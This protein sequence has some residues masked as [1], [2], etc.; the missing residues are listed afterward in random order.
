LNNKDLISI[1]IGY[2]IRPI[3]Q[4]RSVI[5]MKI[6][7][8][9]GLRNK[10]E[11]YKLMRGGTL[12]EA[13]RIMY[14]SLISGFLF[15]VLIFLRMVRWNRFALFSQD[16][17]LLLVYC[18]LLFSLLAL[19]FGIFLCIVASVFRILKIRLSIPFQNLLQTI[20][21]TFFLFWFL[22][23]KYAYL[24]MYYHDF[25]A[26]LQN[27]WI[28]ASLWTLRLLLLLIISWV[29]TIALFQFY[30]FFKKIKKSYVLVLSV[31]L[32]SLFLSVYEYYSYKSGA[33]FDPSPFAVTSQKSKV[34]FIG[35]DGAEWKIIDSLIG[36]NLLPSFKHLKEQGSYG[37]LKTIN[38]ESPG[39][40]TSMVTGVTPRNHGIYKHTQFKF[41]GMKDYIQ[42]PY[43]LGINS[44][45]PTI[46][47]YLGLRL[48][49]ITL[50]TSNKREVPALWNIL[51]LKNR[52]NITTG[53]LATHPVEPIHGLIVSPRITDHY[54]KQERN[55]DDIM[56]YLYSAEFFDRPIKFPDKVDSN[57]PISH[58]VYFSDLALD[59]IRNKDTYE[60]FLLYLEKIDQISHLSW[61][62]MEP[63]KF[64]FVDQTELSE[65]RDSIEREYI[66][67]DEFLGKL[68]EVIDEDYS[69]ILC[70]DHGFGP[71]LFEKDH[72]GGHNN[73]PDGVFIGYG[74]IFKKNHYVEN[75]SVYDICPTILHILGFPVAQD[76]P[77]QVIQQAFAS[78]FQSDIRQID[79]YGRRSTEHLEDNEESFKKEIE[80]LKSLGYIN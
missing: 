25:P 56:R 15:G 32:I 63:E 17:F 37:R 10:F 7:N 18:I 16:V 38:Y 33:K 71:A 22:F 44:F 19:V 69:L 43:Y 4:N 67:K 11:D 79:T 41:P 3:N 46:F 23:S 40:W 51:S 53:W 30:F 1:K 78:E 12:K 49:K 48:F 50:I 27:K 26:F 36:K 2:T 64:F 55:A 14:I 39:I 29:L 72:Y 28:M 34:I 24:G 35:I 57:H 21:P 42:A 13:T 20:V 65:H 61:K 73:C 62:Y 59:L 66:E 74:K 60:L 9:L 68:L 6:R 47:K 45:I 75:V 52:K 80:R 31:I 5:N 8:F 54:S 76:M 77:G 70:S 58:D